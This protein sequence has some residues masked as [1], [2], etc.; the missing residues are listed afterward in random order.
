MTDLTHNP[1]TTETWSPP[2]THS[3]PPATFSGLPV[4]IIHDIALE[5]S[6]Y[7]DLASL[8]A[9]SSRLF[10]IVDPVLYFRA[11]TSY[12]KRALFWAAAHGRV[13]TLRKVLAAGVDPNHVWRSQSHRTE[14]PLFELGPVDEDMT[15]PEQVF[16]GPRVLE[17]NYYL[18]HQDPPRYPRPQPAEPRP[19]QEPAQ[20]K[21]D[22]GG[23][24]FDQEIH[25]VPKSQFSQ[26]CTALHLAVRHDQVGSVEALLDA[27]ADVNASSQGFSEC[28]VEHLLMSYRMNPTAT[29][30]WTPLFVAFNYG[31]LG[32]ARKLLASG[33]SPRLC[34]SDISKES[35][36]PMLTALHAAAAF[37]DVA[38]IDELLSQGTP[39]LSVNSLDSIDQAP[40]VYAYAYSHWETVEWLCRHGASL[41]TAEYGSTADARRIPLLLP[42][43]LWTLRFRDARRLLSLYLPTEI[44]GPTMMFY[45]ML[46]SCCKVA[47]P[48]DIE[49]PLFASRYRDQDTAEL[50]MDFIRDF[51]PKANPTAFELS[52]LFGPSFGGFSPL[53]IAVRNGRIDLVRLL[54][55]LYPDLDDAIHKCRQ[56]IL[57]VAC[58][59]AVSPPS[60]E[61]ITLLLEHGAADHVKALQSL[62]THNTSPLRTR[63]DVPTGPFGEIAQYDPV[64]VPD[65][66]AI[67]RL[68]VESGVAGSREQQLQAINCALRECNIIGLEF[69]LKHGQATTMT[70]EDVHTCLSSLF[71]LAYDH[72]ETRTANPA[73]FERCMF[74]LM[75]LAEQHQVV[76]VSGSILGLLVINGGID[77]SIVEHFLDRSNDDAIE[78]AEEQ[79]M[80]PLHNAVQSERADLVSLL[81]DRGASPSKANSFG[82]T[83]LDLA[84]GSDRTEKGIAE[85][86]IRVFL[87]HDGLSSLQLRASTLP[88]RLLAPDSMSIKKAPPRRPT[89]LEAALDSHSSFLLSLVLDNH[90]PATWPADQLE[91]AVRT[92]VTKRRVRMLRRVLVECGGVVVPMHS[93]CLDPILHELLDMLRLEVSDA[94]RFRNSN[95]ATS[96]GEFTT[97]GSVL[98]AW[99]YAEM[100]VILLEHGRASLSSSAGTADSVTGLGKLYALMY[101]PDDDD[102]VVVPSLLTSRRGDLRALGECLSVALRTKI[103]LVGAGLGGSGDSSIGGGGERKVQEVRV[104]PSAVFSDAVLAHLRDT[105][106]YTDTHA[107]ILPWES[108]SIPDHTDAPGRSK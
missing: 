1:H 89:V 36:T 18:Q 8:A 66:T 80:E 63:V 34:A 7:A 76:D 11:A 91:H 3:P 77:R 105:T 2:P 70:S 96:P 25:Y 51:A 108:V 40:I 45:R 72:H 104:K 12:Q 87:D 107:Y 6:R 106:D 15:M 64:E 27:G 85:A 49:T 65:K 9:T 30:A 98:V 53:G 55:E 47:S 35:G 37:G 31:R 100:V 90:P 26:H 67:A 22:A 54:L 16:G 79:G 99:L 93:L 46:M 101:P 71:A 13:G 73:V 81:L 94:A 57:L 75:D 14:A 4:E 19:R 29:Y 23:R 28:R 48:A 102:A 69:L 42:D 59:Y 38:L 88:S 17:S 33:A 5:L 24:C 103:E 43:A 50:R 92:L 39:G 83:P 52:R 95:V 32:L 58:T 82:S 61:M 68:L 10:N 41:D 60:L 44:S 20:H 74:T 62:T 56:P 86:V 78:R 97:H 84:I 21:K